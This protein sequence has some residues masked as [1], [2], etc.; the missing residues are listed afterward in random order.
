MASTPPSLPDQI[1]GDTDDADIEMEP[2]VDWI[3]RSTHYAEHQLAKLGAADWVTEV[4]RRRWRWVSRIAALSGTEWAKIV[5]LW[6]PDQ[7]LPRQAHRRQGR[8][9]KRWVDDIFAHF[10]THVRE[11]TTTLDDMLEAA[12]TPNWATYE[13]SFCE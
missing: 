12:R 8:Q 5:L 10:K 3:R 2:W 6:H 9:K 1:A 13:E 4:Q 7:V 11:H